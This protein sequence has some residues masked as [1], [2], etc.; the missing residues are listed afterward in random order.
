LCITWCLLCIVEVPHRVLKSHRGAV[1]ALLYPHAVDPVRYSEKFLV[2]GSKDFTVR[3]WDL[4]TAALLR[5]Y[6]VHGGEIQR[7][8]CCPPDFQDV[9]SV[10]GYL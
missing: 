5:T 6:T 8:Y 9:G 10:N 4:T 2:S 7:I 1:T 3:L